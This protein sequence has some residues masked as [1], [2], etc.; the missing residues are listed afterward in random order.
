MFKTVFTLFRGS[1][2]AAGEELEDRT[3]LLIL[4]QQMRDAAA[5]LAFRIAQ[6]EYDDLDDL[7][8]TD[9][10]ALAQVLEAWS[11]RV[12]ELETAIYPAGPE[13]Q[14]PRVKP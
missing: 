4:D 13:E 5:E 10:E 6:G 14:A 11:R 7:Q 9:L 12:A 2:A 1:V 3:A 8:R